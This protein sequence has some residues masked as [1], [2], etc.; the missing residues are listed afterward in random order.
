[1]NK[2]ISHI[3]VLLI[4]AVCAPAAFADQELTVRTIEPL[5][6]D[7]TARTMS[8]NDLHGEKCGLVKVQC[9]LDGMVFR[10]NVMGEVERKEGEYW[11]YLT[12]GTKFLQIAHPQVLPITI[13]IEE[14]MG[15]PIA[16]AMTY[17]LVLG[18]PDAL[19]A[20][21]VGANNANANASAAAPNPAANISTNGTM[22]GKV[23]EETG[24]PLIGCTVNHFRNSH[25][26]TAIASDIDGEYMLKNVQPGDIVQF[27]Y[28]GYRTK[29]V[30]LENAVPKEITVTLREGNP[31]KMEYLVIDPLD[32]SRYYDL[33][34]NELPERPTK[35]GTYLR[36]K[37]GQPQKFTVK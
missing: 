29:E 2:F 30:T 28:I 1:M 24:E 18:I 23:V 10:G 36:V 9:V 33:D 5:P 13:N 27:M 16:S 25:R 7:M 20:V 14:L 19:Y 15:S 4:M 37:N 11:V 26:V 34:G 3:V 35:K 32:D 31:K 17:R 12:K 8:R 22:K 21:V 6:I